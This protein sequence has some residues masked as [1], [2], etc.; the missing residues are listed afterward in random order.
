MTCQVQLAYTHDG[1]EFEDTRYSRKF[2]GKRMYYLEGVPMSRTNKYCSLL[3]VEHITNE[4]T[5]LPEYH[6]YVFDGEILYFE[7]FNST[8]ENFK[9]A[10]SLTSKKYI[11][12]PGC[13]NLYFVIFDMI[14]ACRFYHSIPQCKT[15]AEEYNEM[16]KLF[17]VQPIEGRSDILATKYPHILIATQ[18]S[19]PVPLVN[20]R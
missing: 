7:D 15:F 18:H 16:L 20:Q 14:D 5:Q 13:D 12:A 3:P 8:Q 11:R 19:T 1:R 10:I 9:K 6:N 4:I 2:D 17:E